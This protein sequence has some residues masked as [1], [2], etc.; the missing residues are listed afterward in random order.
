L[1]EGP[2][3]G[4]VIRSRKIKF[5]PDWEAAVTPVVDYLITRKEVD[6]DRIAL[7]DTVSADI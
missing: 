4:R 7:Y 3:Q 6:P 1:F 5:R 2:G